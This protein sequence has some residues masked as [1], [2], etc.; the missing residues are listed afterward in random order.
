[1]KAE[2]FKKLN[3]HKGNRKVSQESRMSSPPHQGRSTILAPFPEVGATGTVWQIP[4][5]KL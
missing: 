1:M 5:R 2:H 3:Y 4:P